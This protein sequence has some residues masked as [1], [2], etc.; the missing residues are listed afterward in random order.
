MVRLTK[1]TVCSCVLNL[2]RKKNMPILLLL[3]FCLSLIPG[4]TYATCNF[5]MGS[6]TNVPGWVCTTK[7]EA[8]DMCDA[9]VAQDIAYGGRY[10]G[11]FCEGGYIDYYGNNA[12]DVYTYNLVMCGGLPCGCSDKAIMGAYG[13]GCPVTGPLV[14]P[15]CDNSNQCCK[16]KDLCCGDPCCGGC[17]L[18]SGSGNGNNPGAGGN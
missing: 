17:C 12:F 7:A 3:L 18:P 1:K 16:S 2:V 8:K 5:Y 15:C 4:T 9:S 11:T 14:D 13:Y 10:C 6:A